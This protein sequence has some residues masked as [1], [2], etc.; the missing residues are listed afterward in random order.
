MNISKSFHRIRFRFDWVPVFFSASFFFAGYH[1]CVKLMKLVILCFCYLDTLP[2]AIRIYVLFSVPDTLCQCLKCIMRTKIYSKL[3]WFMYPI[4]TEMMLSSQKKKTWWQS[5]GNFRIFFV[6]LNITKHR[7]MKIRNRASLSSLYLFQS[8]GFLLLL[9]CRISLDYSTHMTFFLPE[10]TLVSDAD[11]RITNCEHSRKQTI[12]QFFF[13]GKNG[14]CFFPK[15]SKF[16]AS[17]DRW[18]CN[19]NRISFWTMWNDTRSSTIF[20]ESLSIKFTSFKWIGHWTK[21]VSRTNNEQ[22]TSNIQM[23]C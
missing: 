18:L 17:M 8:H 10:I 16:K 19:I 14:D 21:Y 11:N 22:W 9:F 15:K 20:R 4:K 1:W 23:R 12:W 2:D 13:L 6:S 3:H 5:N 7:M